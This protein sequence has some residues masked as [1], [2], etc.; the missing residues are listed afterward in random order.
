MT[1][2]PT[3]QYRQQNLLS[4]TN[5]NKTYSAVQTTTKPTQQYRQQQNLLSSTDNNKRETETQ[6]DRDKERE[7]R[8]HTQSPGAYPNCIFMSLADRALVPI[9]SG[10]YLWAAEGAVQRLLQAFGKPLHRH[11]EVR[12][13]RLI[14]TNNRVS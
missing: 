9:T 7:T 8:T 3:Q 4:S 12:E 14:N 6:K 13:P 1:T 10:Q 5:N 2:K 11:K